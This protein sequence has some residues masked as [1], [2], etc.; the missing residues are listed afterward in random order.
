MLSF[1][2][3]TVILT[4]QFPFYKNRSF[5][6]SFMKTNRRQEDVPDADLLFSYKNSADFTQFSI[7][8][9]SLLL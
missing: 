2:K 8:L 4:F 5:N 9:V 1:K 6:A 3:D 7:L